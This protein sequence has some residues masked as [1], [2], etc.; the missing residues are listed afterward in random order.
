[1]AEFIKDEHSLRENSEGMVF[2]DPA[3]ETAVSAFRLVDSRDRNTY[4]GDLTDGGVKKE[5]VVRF[6]DV[7]ID[8]LDGFSW[9]RECQADGDRSFSGPSFSACD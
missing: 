8:Q 5:V 7:A 3:A 6:L 4:G 1:M 9:Q 2:T